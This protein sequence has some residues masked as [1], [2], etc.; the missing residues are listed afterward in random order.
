MSSADISSGLT[1]SNPSN[2]VWSILS[3]IL[4]QKIKQILE[5]YHILTKN[6]GIFIVSFY[7]PTEWLFFLWKLQKV[8]NCQFLPIFSAKNMGRPKSWKSAYVIYKMVPKNESN[9]SC[10]M[11]I[12]MLFY[13]LF[14]SK[15]LWVCFLV[16]KKYVK[17]FKMLSKIGSIKNFGLTHR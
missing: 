2:S 1:Y 10:E 16:D 11:K 3:I 6:D 8:R 5:K 9:N 12:F 4:L 13:N 7:I 14:D 17:H 15:V